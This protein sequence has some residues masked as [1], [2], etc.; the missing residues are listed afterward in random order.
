MTRLVSTLARF[1]AVWLFL[2]L[3]SVYFLFQSGE[4]FSSDGEIMYQT[5]EQLA[6]H[7]SIDLKYDSGLP[8]IL[9]GV[10]GKF[11]SKYGLGQPLLS[12]IAYDAGRVFH[13]LFFPDANGRDLSHFLVSMLNAV[14]TPLTAIVLYFFARRLFNSTRL[15]IVLALLYGIC[16][17]AWP[18]AK[19]YFSEP[20][21]TLCVLSSF[22]ALYRVS[23]GG[24][25]DP[26]A[27]SVTDDAPSTG[28]RRAAWLSLSG[29]LAGY[30]ILTKVSGAVLLPVIVAYGVY[31][32][33][34]S[35]GQGEAYRRPLLQ[36]A[37]LRRLALDALYF[38]I[39]LVIVG[40]VL[41]WHNYARFGNP[42][43]N[44]YS[45]ET[46]STPFLVGFYG[47]LFSS[48][49][50]IFLYS[51]VILLAPFAFRRFFRHRPVE[52]VLFAVVIGATILYYSPWW[53]WYGGWGWGPRFM[54]PIL[55]FMVLLA[56]AAFRI[57]WVAIFTVVILVPW[58]IFMQVLGAT[59]DFNVYINSVYAGV[60][61]NEFMYMFYPW[62]SPIVGHIVYLFEGRAIAIES[63]KLAGRGFSPE[64]AA[65]AP[66][67]AI[68]LGLA[69]ASALGASYFKA[70]RKELKSE[71]D[72]ET[73]LSF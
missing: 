49:K 15:A 58:S 67:A 62:M 29:L 50:S 18:Y 20:L 51:P 27:Q 5:T 55:P 53:A 2:F 19:F 45:D 10:D 6:L 57:R 33:L 72:T 73:E 69:S 61:A 30:L 32:S 42:F 25:W 43:D 34:W 48:G 38:V 56:G 59:V 60:D 54:V 40:I 16:T 12:V 28:W 44:G 35:H 23:S 39:P 65:V 9:P 7:N 24:A 8:S 22:Y 63:F 52:A 46:Y 36:K 41:L 26:A 1:P 21:Y 64:F 17:S 13:K 66:Y 3:F 31:V 47:L 68:L 70:R 14:L 4:L 11:Y 37:V 71:I